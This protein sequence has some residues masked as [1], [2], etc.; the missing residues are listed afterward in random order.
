MFGIIFI[1]S[2]NACK[3]DDNNDPS[4]M[5]SW[6]RNIGTSNEIPVQISLFS[7]KYFEWI[8]LIP[9][10][11]YTR[12]PAEYEYVGGVLTITKD[13]TC[14][15]PGKYSVT[16]KG[17]TLTLE[18]IEDD[19]EARVTRLAGNWARKNMMTDVRIQGAWSK[20]VTIADTARD[21]F[22]I[23]QQNGVFEWLISKETPLYMSQ[24][25][26]YAVGDQYVAVYS[27]LDCASIVGYY[28][29]AI[30]DEKR[31]VLT[32]VQDYCTIRTPALSGTWN[33]QTN[34]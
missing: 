29:Y 12:V 17:N 23:P 33:L 7:N 3:N 27:F 28:T 20:T 9:V 25:G 6:V 24:F 2:M 26:R 34:Y 13:I 15:E 22:F 16:V 32:P 11:E 19:C 14:P 30:Q 10:E 5:G 21:L 18:V 8:P 4:I 1:F 31:L